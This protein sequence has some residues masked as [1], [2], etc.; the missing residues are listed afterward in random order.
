M[1]RSRRHPALAVSGLILVSLVALARADVIVTKPAGGDDIAIF[2][3]PTVGLPTPAVTYV[4]GLPPGTKQ[5]HGI[6]CYGNTCIVGDFRNPRLFIV[7]AASA[8]V[9]G[10]LDTP[11]TYTGKGAVAVNRAAT[12]VL[13]T[14]T[15]DPL[16][17]TEA[18]LAVIATPVTPS[19]SVGTV[20]L[21]GIPDPPATRQIAFDPQDRAF[22]CHRDGV[23][24]LEPPYTSIAFTIPLSAPPFPICVSLALT[25][26]GNTLLVP[27]WSAGVFEG[28]VRVFT[29][30]FSAASTSQRIKISDVANPLLPSL[31][32][33]EVT[34]DGSKAL[35]VSASGRDAWAISAP[36]G[37]GSTVERLPLPPDPLAVAA[38]FEDLAISPDGN[39]VV[40]TG[41]IAGAPTLPFILAPF[42]AAGATV[43]DVP[44]TG[45]RGAGSVRFV[46]PNGGGGSTPEVC[47]DCIDNDGDGLTD[48]EDP[49]CCTADHALPTTLRRVR[50]KPG[51]ATSKL[52]LNGSLTGAESVNPRQQGVRVQFRRED[53][54]TE[55]LCATIPSARF[56]PKGK[57]FKFRDKTG[58]VADAKGIS[59]F[60]LKVKK[61]G[62]AKL[63]LVGKRAAF[64]TP[65][66][67]PLRITVGFTGSDA[68]AN[69]CAQATP[70]LKATRKGTVKF[71]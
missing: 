38:G 44:I 41:Q 16:T 27:E 20:P 52:A 2:R 58:A 25:P 51:G 57:A 71:P 43:H 26:D 31:D 3:T 30:P 70:V 10:I 59:A 50:I 7:D 9:T 24:V 66:A 28:R 62:S 1:H 69:R 8:T 46:F 42:T 61:N 63:K 32:A 21:P 45:G 48:F 12:F 23:S 37:P 14:S 64:A 11:T 4:T 29:A 47:D 19:S 56:S 33:I 17:A 13:A 22:V 67:D 65:P 18:H 68:A 40:L 39:L 60:T 54:G 35:V 55:L 34:P 53:T 49:A 6:D 36:F 15:D 5:P